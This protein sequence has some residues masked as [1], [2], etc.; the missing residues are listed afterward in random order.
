METSLNNVE[1]KSLENM[2]CAEV[3]IVDDVKEEPS[4]NFMVAFSSPM[5]GL[6]VGDTPLSV[7]TILDNDDGKRNW[8][9]VHFRLVVIGP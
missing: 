2:T 5:D 9:T 8:S 4:E 6:T 7:V 1:F 3:P